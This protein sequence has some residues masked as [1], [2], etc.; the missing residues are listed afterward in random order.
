MPHPSVSELYNVAARLSDIDGGLVRAAADELVE[1]RKAQ[2]IAEE[3][4]ARLR[5]ALLT[6][7]VYSQPY[8]DGSFGALDR[9][10]VRAEQAMNGV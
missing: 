5:D 2:R 7:S 3:E 6:I 9:I 8:R 10:A 4:V 1:R